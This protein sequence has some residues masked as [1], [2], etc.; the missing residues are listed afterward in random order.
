M[1]WN[2]YPGIG[3]VRH[4][5]STTHNLCLCSRDTNYEACFGAHYDFHTNPKIATRLPTDPTRAA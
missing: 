1:P 5:E 4:F 3:F 2:Q